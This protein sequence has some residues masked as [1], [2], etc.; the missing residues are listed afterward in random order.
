M[1]EPIEKVATT[2]MSNFDI[3]HYLP[4]VRIVPYNELPKY[5]DIERLLPTN[6]SYLVL[7]YQ[8]SENSGHWCGMCRY[9]DCV[10]F[11][12]SY[13]NPPDKQLK[14]TPKPLRED[15]GIDANYLSR[16]LKATRLPCI[17]NK[18]K[19]QSED[20]D[21]ATCGRHVCWRLMNFLKR[22]MTLKDYNEFMKKSGL[23]ADLVV[24]E[25]IDRTSE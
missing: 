17:Y 6:G 1:T 12:D 4:D 19:Y 25:L 10:E 8:D 24:S 22:D 2:P 13:G 14:W 5:G 20:P 3:K 9:M 11:F 18:V 16:M 15:I 23:P 7:L 21:I